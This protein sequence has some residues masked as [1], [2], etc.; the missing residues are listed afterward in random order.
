MKD[1]LLILSAALWLVQLVSPARQLVEAGKSSS[2]KRLVSEVSP[3]SSSEPD[4]GDSCTNDYVIDYMKLVLSWGPG[5]CSTGG[6]GCKGTAAK[7]YIQGL[8]SKLKN[9]SEAPRCCTKEKFEAEK[10][11]PI[12]AELETK[13]PAMEITK[14]DEDV[15]TE[16]WERHGRCVSKVK[17]VHSVFNYF[18]FA[19]R[20]FN[21]LRLKKTFTSKS[22]IPTDLTSYWGRSIMTVLNDR[23]GVRA[24]LKCEHLKYDAKKIVLTEVNFCF[25]T[26]LRPIDCPYSDSRCTG[27]IMLLKSVHN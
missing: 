23:Y 1:T 21:K 4:G 17:G 27:E 22:F 3:S 5:V 15:W 9:T 2:R 10:I 18:T 25:D 14:R 11:A 6:P 26:K 13:W 8:R 12:Q 20:N 16:E 19:L 24:E 7:F